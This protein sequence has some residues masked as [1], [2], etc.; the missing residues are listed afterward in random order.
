ML[1]Y[2]REGEEA[3]VDEPGRTRLANLL[4]GR[5]GSLELDEAA[6]VLATIEFPGLDMG[7]TLHNI[8]VLA[9]EV[10]RS[11]QGASN[12]RDF[13][14]GANDFLFHELG[15]RGNTE[16]YYD[17]LNSCL[18]QVLQ[19]R[20][21]IPITL[22]VLYIE[23][24]RRLNRP[25]FGIGLPGH[26][27]VQ[28]DD[29]DYSTFID[30]FNGGALLRADQCYDLAQMTVGDP[31]VLAPVDKRQILFRIVNNLRGIYFSRRSY[32]K[33]LE[34][35]NLLIDATPALADHYKQRGLLYLQMQRLGAARA[36]LERYL[37]LAPNAEDRAE[38]EQQVRALVLWHA[39]LN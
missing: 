19:R 10:A 37:K 24:A 29:G 36:D 38:M 34:V 5:D 16:D 14:A 1:F 15:L 35:M 18:N 27:I 26:F 33:A 2:G 3:S 30:P 4:A 21:G 23:I 20:M 8:D 31:R 6:L 28:Y 32:L 7:P 17:P 25:I 39:S 9:E 11:T 13:V 22:S 12:G